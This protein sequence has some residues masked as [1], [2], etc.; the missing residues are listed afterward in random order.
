MLDPSVRDEIRAYVAE[1]DWAQFHTPENLAKSI[2]IEAAELLE[3]FQWAPDADLD[4]LRGELADVLIYCLLLADRTGL[5]PAEIILEKI[6]VTRRK[7]PVDKARGRST[8][9]DAL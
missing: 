6:D 1:R 4:A 7:Y 2:S 3:C 9:H 8:K 5:D